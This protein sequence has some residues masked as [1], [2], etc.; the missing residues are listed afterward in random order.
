MPRM[1]KQS[2]SSEPERQIR[3]ALTPEAEERLLISLAIDRAKQQLIDGT[4]SA[5]VITHFLKLGA[6]TAKLEREKLEKENQLLEAKT[7]AI[8]SMDRQ[9][10]MYADAIEAM[11]RYSGHGKSAP[12]D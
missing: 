12:N 9:E 6:S 5:Q 10:A 1:K 11:K 3:P 4:A 8:G 2:S 7:K